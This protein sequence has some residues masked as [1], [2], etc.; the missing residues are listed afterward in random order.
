MRSGLVEKTN[1]LKTHLSYLARHK[2]GQ[3]VNFHGD[4]GPE[5]QI[6]LMVILWKIL[7]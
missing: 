1:H 2:E 3:L 4:D 5:T 7:L 6:Q